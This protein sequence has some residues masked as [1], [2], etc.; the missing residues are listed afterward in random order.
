MGIFFVKY[1]V[2]LILKVLRHDGVIK[3]KHFR[4]YWSLRGTTGDW[5]FPRTK[6]SNVEF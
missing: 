3:W 5:W 2:K 4:R 6:A 1:D